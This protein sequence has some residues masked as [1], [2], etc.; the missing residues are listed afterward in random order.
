[1]KKENIKYHLCFKT[2]RLTL[3]GSSHKRKCS[4]I[5]ELFSNVHKRLCFLAVS[6]CS[7]TWRYVWKRCYRFFVERQH[8]VVFF[9]FF[10]NLIACSKDRPLILSLLNYFVIF[11]SPHARHRAHKSQCE[12]KLCANA[13][14]KIWQL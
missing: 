14:V 2:T 10:F 12:T 11:S 6:V 13:N 7:A 4:E 5:Y 9:F 3:H 8:L 1:M